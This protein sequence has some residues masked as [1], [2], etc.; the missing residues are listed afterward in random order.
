M[1]LKK[2]ILLG[3]AAV[4]LIIAAACGFYINDYYHAGEEAA[5]AAGEAAADYTSQQDGD[6]LV[7]LPEGT[8]GTVLD[9]SGPDD[10]GLIFY[11]GG[12]VEYTAYAPLMEAF[13]ERGV[14]CILVE[15][16]GNLA[17]LDVNAADGYREEFPE[18][19]HWYVG[20]HSLGGSMAASYAA[21]HAGDLDGLIL[22]AAYSTAD[23]NGTGL[24]VLSVYGSE[25]GV[26]NMSKYDEYRQNLPEDTTTE[27]V[28]EGG[29]HAGFGDYGAQEGDGEA[30]V[31][32]EKQREET[33]EAFMEI[34]RGVETRTET[35]EE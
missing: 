9:G 3:A 32:G 25:D 17:V 31:N 18:I 20:G 27:M 21:K 22:L 5:L 1:S 4:V 16:P 13:A 24:D 14:L 33:A 11:P 10:A 2:K 23:L 19:E 34:L 7:F 29:N 12:K 35:Q 15:M 26:L 28:I 6:T 8:D 30:A